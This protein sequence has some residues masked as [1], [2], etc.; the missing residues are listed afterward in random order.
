MLSVSDEGLAELHRMQAETFERVRA[1]A[2]APRDVDHIVVVNLHSFEIG[3]EDG[4]AWE[5]VAA[6]RAAE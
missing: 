1:F 4:E 2:T 5:S 6:D 3:P